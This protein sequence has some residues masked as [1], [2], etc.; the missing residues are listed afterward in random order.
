MSSERTRNRTDICLDSVSKGEL[1]PVTWQQAL[2]GAGTSSTAGTS[3][4]EGFIGED[5]QA[6]I[7]K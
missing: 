3:L 5:D 1:Q 6:P 7:C 2:Y 4:E